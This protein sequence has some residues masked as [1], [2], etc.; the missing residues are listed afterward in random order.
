MIFLEKMPASELRR[1][2][3]LTV[4]NRQKKVTKMKKILSFL[5]LLLLIF[6][7][8]A[9][10]LGVTAYF[11]KN[12]PSSTGGGIVF[13]ETASGFEILQP[14][15]VEVRFDNQN[16]NPIS[17]ERTLTVRNEWNYKVEV[18]EGECITMYTQDPSDSTTLMAEHEFCR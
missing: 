1:I 18:A 17:F 15:E 5:V 9:G 7:L 3:Y 12:S 8:L 11:G 13:K 14:N 4:E 2:S 16:G 10:L 6:L